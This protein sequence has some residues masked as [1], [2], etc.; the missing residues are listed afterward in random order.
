MLQK[1]SKKKLVMLAQKYGETKV[2]IDHSIMS[3]KDNLVLPFRPQEIFRKNFS[4]T[5][6]EQKSL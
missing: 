3:T 6:S 4:C 1:K 2:T 5:Y